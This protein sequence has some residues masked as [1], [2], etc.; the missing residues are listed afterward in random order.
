MGVK[1]A[2]IVNFKT[3][4]LDQLEHTRVAVDAS[5][6][7]FQ[8]LN[9]IRRQNLPLFNYEG[10]VVSHIYGVFYRTTNFLE[11]N[12]KPIIVFDGAHP[13]LKERREHLVESL[14]KEYSYLRKARE[15]KN[16][17]VARTLSLSNEILY[18]TI[19][20]ETQKLLTTM[21]VPWVK[22]PGEGEAEAAYMTRIGKADHVLTQ[23]YDALLFG[24]R[25][26]LR[27]LDLTENNVQCA[28]LEEVLKLQNISYEQLVDLAI[29]VGTDFNLGVKKVG[30]KKA[31]KLIRKHGDIRGVFSGAGLEPFDV[32]GVREIFL[33]P[34]VVEPQIIFNAPNT[35]SLRRL[36]EEFSMKPERIDKGIRRLVKA[37]KESQLVQT[38][39]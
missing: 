24:A 15:N 13:R 12:I 19:I 5:N 22:S 32:E 9:K 21:G 39:L 35:G 7:L 30:A 34:D 6:M 33:N 20:N 17:N 14:V 11:H 3:L 28:T 36:L 31:L 23:D 29:L 26:I 4:S 16:Y 1:L 37:Y 25:S 2:S 38:T 8:F 27:N 10:R 18:D